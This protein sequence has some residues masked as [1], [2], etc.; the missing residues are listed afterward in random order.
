MQVFKE[1]GKPEYPGRKPLRAEKRNKKT[2]PTYDTESGY[3]TW[4]TLVGDECSHHHA[5]TALQVAF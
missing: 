5:T 3:R 2:Q 4:A 1:R